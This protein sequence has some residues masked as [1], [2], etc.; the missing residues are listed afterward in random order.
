MTIRPAIAA[1]ISALVHMGERFLAA[2]PY[3]DVLTKNPQQMATLC[4][5]LIDGT[6]VILV[7]DG[8]SGP[9]GMI[10]L[11]CAPH[12]LSG[13]LSVGE[14]F[15]WVDPDQRGQGVRLM[16][17]AETWA[18][19]RGAVAMQMVAPDDRVG[20]LYQRLGYQPVERTY[21]RVLHG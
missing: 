13:D 2:S 14:V 4:Q 16:R 6:G 9:V 7:L 3:A 5:Q 15:W 18:R 21:L 20:A 8:G 12:F 10:G 1:D 11:Y 17:A 19:E